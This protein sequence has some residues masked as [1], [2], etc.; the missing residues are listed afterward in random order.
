VLEH[1]E[2]PHHAAP[3]VLEGGAIHVDGEGACLTTERCL[4]DPNRNPELDKATIEALLSAHLGVRRVIW[5][6][7]GLRD[8]DSGGH[9]DNL[10]C[11]VRPGVVLALAAG[12]PEDEN[13]AAL[14]DNLARLRAA[15][16]A[17]GRELEVI[18]VAQ[19][20]P[21]EGDDGRR[22]ALSYV[23]FYLANG[24]V[25][26]PSF[27]DSKDKAAYETLAACFPGRELRQVP[28]LDILRGGGG[29]HSIT[30]QQPSAAG[31]ESGAEGEGEAS[32]D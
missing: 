8:D 10:A 12:D 29:I 25:I 20:G 27:E 7:E 14:A 11:F 16:D 30:Q 1:L 26:L 22:L 4:L 19:P 5:L 18:E 3:L 6:G 15:R 17:K 28:A 2:L 23:N 24:A 21:V 13:H 32:P 31:D 9:V